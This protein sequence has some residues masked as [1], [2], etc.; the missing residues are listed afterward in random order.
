MSGLTPEEIVNLGIWYHIQFA[1]E[2]MMEAAKRR[3]L[4]YLARKRQTLPSGQS[5]QKG[6]E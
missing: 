1:N 2:R 6:A 5:Y 3:Y 4:R